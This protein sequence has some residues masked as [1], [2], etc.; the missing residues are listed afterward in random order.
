MQRIIDYEREV[1]AAAFW[2][3]RLIYLFLL[4]LQL[5]DHH[6]VCLICNVL[7]GLA[8][9]A[10]INQMPLE[11]WI[12]VI[13]KVIL[14]TQQGNIRFAN[15]L[16]DISAITLK[17]CCRTHFII[18][19]LDYILKLYLPPDKY[20]ASDLHIFILLNCMCIEGQNTLS[21]DDPKFS[22]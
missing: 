22:F 19:Q 4:V 2:K 17:Y 20:I 5:L 18:F 3:K 12:P 1:S 11:I 16:T 8:F 7:F 6:V 10:N 21:H 14:Q 15:C 13:H 9:Q